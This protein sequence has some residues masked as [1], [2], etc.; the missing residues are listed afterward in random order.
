MNDLIETWKSLPKR[1]RAPAGVSHAIL[2]HIYPPGLAMGAR[3]VL[4]GRPLTIGRANTCDI[5]IPDSSVSRQHA[6]IQPEPEGYQVVDLQRMNGTF[7]NDRASVDSKLK[8]ADYLRVGHCIY[9]FLTGD[10]VEAAYHEEIYRRTI[11]DALTDMNNKR[12]LLE[13]LERE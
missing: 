12:Y 5:R 9:R 10:N 13:Y 2:V 8:D 7:V 11:V 6:R 4:E 3:Y 1:P